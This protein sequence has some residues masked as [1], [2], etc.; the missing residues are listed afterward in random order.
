M[1]GLL[2]DSSGRRTAPGSNLASGRNRQHTG[3]FCSMGPFLESPGCATPALTTLNLCPRVEGTVSRGQ[4]TEDGWCE[5]HVPLGPNDQFLEGEAHCCP[6]L[7]E[8][9]GSGWATVGLKDTQPRPRCSRTGTPGPTPR[10]THPV[11][12]HTSARCHGK[13]E[14]GNS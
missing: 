4:D 6:A 3:A 13:G 9:L 8:V 5:S 2:A 7:R 12:T 1:V 14:G 10:H 11:V